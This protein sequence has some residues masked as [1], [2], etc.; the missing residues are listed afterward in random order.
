METKYCA[1]LR[2]VNVNGTNMKMAEVISVFEACKMKH[3][4]SVLASGNILFTSDKNKLALRN[5]LESAM[6][7][8]FR[9]EAFLFVKSD[10][11]IDEMNDNNP[12]AES[13]DFHTYIF[14]AESGFENTLMTE[15]CKAQNAQGEEAEICNGLLYWKIKKGATLNSEFSKILGKKQFKD[16]FTTRNIHTI[17]KITRKM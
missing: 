5:L 11:E 15:F 9:Y 8:H 1:F 7:R 17:E 4:S 6:A 13:N 3:V 12:F 16:K 14:I 10:D 2:G